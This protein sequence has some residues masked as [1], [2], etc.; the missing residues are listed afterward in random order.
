MKFKQDCSKNKYRNIT[1]YSLGVSV[2]SLSEMAGMYESNFDAVQRAWRWK[3]GTL[4]RAFQNRTCTWICGIP[5]SCHIQVVD[6][7]I[8]QMNTDFETL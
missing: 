1:E 6:S 4:L 5:K 2:N 3:W 7:D 8:T